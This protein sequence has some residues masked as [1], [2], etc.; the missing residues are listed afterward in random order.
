MDC[1]E[2]K[3]R[4]ESYVAGKLA[5]DEKGPFEAHLAECA[6][7]RLDSE[8]TRAARSTLATPSPAAQAPPDRAAEPAP[9]QPKTSPRNSA[10]AKPAGDWTLESIFGQG[11]A[12]PAGGA[13]G[14]AAP[15]S[16]RSAPS[17]ATSVPQPAAVPATFEELDTP[18]VPQPPDLEDL[19][20][21]EADTDDTP[22]NWDFEPTDGGGEAKPPE[23]SLFFA[24]EALSRA[25]A[26]GK[27][28]SS[29]LRLVLWCAGGVVGLGLLGLSVWVALTIRQPSPP[30]ALPE[31]NPIGAS[32]GPGAPVTP[33]AD[34]VPE[35]Q[36]GS[37]AEATVESADESR[38]A[39]PPPEAAAGARSAQPAPSI[40]SDPRSAPPPRSTTA[41]APR[42]PPASRVTA[43]RHT[44]TTPTESRNSQRQLAALRP[45]GTASGAPEP[46]PSAPAPALSDEPPFTF[47]N[48]ASGPQGS[49]PASQ[50]AAPAPAPPSPT[51][52]PQTAVPAPAPLPD[53][54]QRPIER[55]H[56][57]TLNAEQNADL[58]ALR[59]LREAWR[60]FVK[61]SIGPERARAKR[62][63][64]DCLWA[65]QTLSAKTS[66]QK[67]ALAAYRDYILN[68]PAGGADSRTVARMRQLED[69]LTESR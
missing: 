48:P 49:G 11:G 68:A 55:L 21:S 7:C 39:V 29:V 5:D 8:L 57:A 53:A 28:K 12:A 4:I 1:A 32:A 47:S 30:T 25:D 3:L 18:E 44:P 2:A 10:A 58:P 45:A 16:P 33:G 66:D 22:P 69:A 6:E 43:V 26:S 35:P 63:L 50:G 54:A 46:E 56:L 24:E 41:S 51:A 67:E 37:G 60:G 38:G 42:V 31:Q 52:T 15:A 34:A 17:P 40:V 9:Q 65:L 27:G 64:A 13:P 14:T 59:K 19:G 20:S 36:P 61:T 62:E 23:G